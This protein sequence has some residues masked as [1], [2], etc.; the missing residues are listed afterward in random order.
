MMKLIKKVKNRSLVLVFFIVLGIKD[1]GAQ[2]HKVYYTD[3]NYVVRVMENPK[4]DQYYFKHHFLN[5]P[6][7]DFKDSL[8]DGIWEMYS[9]NGKKKYLEARGMFENYLKQGRFEYFNS[10]DGKLSFFYEF[11]NGEL[12]GRYASFVIDKLE[13]EGFYQFGKRDGYFIEYFIRPSSLR[14]VRFFKQDSLIHWMNYNLENGIRSVE[15]F[16]DDTFKN[17]IYFFYDS[18]GYKKLSYT[19]SKGKQIKTVEYYPKLNSIKI[20]AE[21]EF[22]NCIESWD[23]LCEV[24]P[25]NGLVRFFDIEGNIVKVEKFVDGKKV[26]QS[27]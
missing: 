4:Q 11:L 16:G 10:H 25:I 1:M 26:V 12:H 3:T 27:D 18:L 23:N 24:T 21:G 14:R 22:L 6:M 5:Y 7:Y 13:G 17:G 15:G 19:F 2:V 9:T 8:S 20:I